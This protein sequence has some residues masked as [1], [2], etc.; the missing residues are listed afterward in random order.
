MSNGRTGVHQGSRNRKNLSQI[1]SVSHITGI[2][3]VENT[4]AIGPQKTKSQVQAIQKLQDTN[5]DEESMTET[6]MNKEELNSSA[7]SEFKRCDNSKKSVTEIFAER[8]QRYK[9]EQMK[10]LPLSDQLD[11][12][13]PQ[14]LS[15]FSTQI[16]QTMLKDEVKHMVDPNYLQ[17]VQ[18]E[19]KDTSRAFLIEWIIDVHRKFRLTPECLYVAI[20]IIDQFMSKKKIQKN[21]LHLL[22]V[23]T[24]FLA[25]KYEEIYPPELRDFLAVSENKFTK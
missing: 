25:S 18:T 10:T 9:R 19:I 8:K 5:D 22:G 21:Q 6:E 7:S 24:L 16:Y 4:N 2:T 23:S 3:G 14:V 17:K 15:E 12:R 20:Y 13:N 11:Y 1:S